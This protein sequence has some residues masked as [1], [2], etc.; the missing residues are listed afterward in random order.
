M[1]RTRRRRPARVKPHRA[2]DPRRVGR[3]ECDAWVAYYR[4]EWLTFMRS[5]IGLT[6]HTFALPWPQ[7]LWG[8][9]LV[10]RA[11][12]LWAPFPDND[13]AGARRSMEG[14][15]RLV[16][17]HYGETIDPARASVLEVEWW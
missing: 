4:R 3:L 14:F 1:A 16:A 17:R 10:L 7:T 11:N 5:A 9:W 15:Y 12:Q 8:A 13:P 2:F 6:R